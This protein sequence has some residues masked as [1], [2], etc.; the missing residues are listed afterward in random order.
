MSVKLFEHFL[1]NMN[2]NKHPNLEDLLKVKKAEQPDDAFWEKFDRDLQEK[3]LQTF[4]EQEPWYQYWAGSVSR[5]ARSA[6]M[7]TGLVFLMGIALFLN[8]SLDRGNTFSDMNSQDEGFGVFEGVMGS[9]E[10]NDYAVVANDTLEKDY[11]VEVISIKGTSDTHDFE[12]DAI[13]VAIGNTVDYS[14]AP[15][16]ASAN[17]LRNPKQFTQLASFAF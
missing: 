12:A 2:I 9:E 3:T 4:I 7:A 13:S 17:N 1:V 14:D 15:V 11:A 16:Y 8:T 10:F 6:S 5:Y